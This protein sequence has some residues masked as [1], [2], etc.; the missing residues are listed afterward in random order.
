MQNSMVRGPAF[1]TKLPNVRR[2]ITSILDN[3]IGY[4]LYQASQY[5]LKIQPII[6]RGLYTVG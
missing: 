1:Y 6:S 3:K 5:L 2:K 4:G